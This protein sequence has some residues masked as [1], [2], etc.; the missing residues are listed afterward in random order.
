MKSLEN[1]M[2]SRKLLVKMICILAT[3]MSD[4]CLERF[5]IQSENYA[6]NLVVEGHI[7]TDVHKQQ[8]KLSTTSHINELKVVPETGCQ[9]S[10]EAGNGESYSFTESAPGVYQA[11]PFG[12]IVGITYKLRIVRADGRRYSSSEVEMRPTPA[13][14]NIY[15]RYLSDL[16]PDK[17]GV[18]IYVDTEDPER[19]IR[20]FRWQYVETYV[21]QTPFPSF[22]EWLGGNEW[23]TRTQ[24]VGTCYPTDSSSNVLI[25]STVGLNESKVSFPLRFF[26]KDSYALRIKYSVMVKQYSLSEQGYRYWNTLKAVN[27]NQGTVY[28]KQPGTVAGNIKAE[29]SDEVVLGYFDACAVSSKR[30]F[31]TPYQFEAAGYFPPHYQ[32]SCK[33]LLPVIAPVDE[34]GFYMNQNPGY[35]I[36]D[37]TAG[38]FELLPKQCCDCTDLGT[39]IQPPFWQ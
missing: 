26:D 11:A 21:V 15:G 33:F 16:P 2:A 38:N 19:R 12:G 36:W 27:E 28:D 30:I 6:E 20:F 18:Q 9:V 31:L 39:N 17:R 29:G 13:I 32:T 5:D 25:E 22:F 4:G 8:I 14:G 23:T 1:E 37:A 24:P 10:V 34:I 3:L 7:T 35:L